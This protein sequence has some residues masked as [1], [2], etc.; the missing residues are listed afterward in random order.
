M[1]HTNRELTG[2]EKVKNSSAPYIDLS[3]ELKEK[4]RE[5]AT[6]SERQ[7]MLLW[8]DS[9]HRLRP[10]ARGLRRKSTG[11]CPYGPHLETEVS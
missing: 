2:R 5:A 7:E 1:S 6:P 3:A 9:Y 8:P 11:E 4:V 10:R